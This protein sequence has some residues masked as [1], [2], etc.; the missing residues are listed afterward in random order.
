MPT[1]LSRNA[2]SDAELDRYLGG[3][4]RWHR[5]GV[6]ISARF[7]FESFVDAFGFMS[8]AALVAERMNHHP[9][10]SNSYNTVDVSLTTHDRGGPT[11]LDITLATAMS[12]IA[13]RCGVS[14]GA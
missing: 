5:D 11:M 10:W 14:D 3:L 9:D 12:D 6:A 8:S 1:G 4:D 7:T 13:A 2:L